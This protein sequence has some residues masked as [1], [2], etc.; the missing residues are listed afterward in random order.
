MHISMNLAMA[1]LYGLYMLLFTVEA[2]AI[3]V[4]VDMG[5]WLFRRR[6]RKQGRK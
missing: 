6:E 3:V 5:I 4:L 1:M 2:F